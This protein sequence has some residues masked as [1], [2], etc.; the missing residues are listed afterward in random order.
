MYSQWHSGNELSIFSQV[1]H[2]SANLGY[3]QRQILY[4]LLYCICL[5]AL[6]LSYFSDYS[7]CPVQ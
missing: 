2:L 6:I 4:F 7:F 3:T 5:A 1:L